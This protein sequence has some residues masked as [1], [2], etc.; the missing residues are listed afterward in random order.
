MA[1]QAK[2][3]SENGLLRKRINEMEAVNRISQTMNSSLNVKETLES[4]MEAVIELG[5]ADRAL[6][7]LLNEA[8]TH[9]IPTVSR[10]DTNDIDLNFEVA[11]ESSLFRY[12]LRDRVPIVVD[13]IEMDSRVNRSHADHLGTTSFIIVPMISK[14]RVIGIIGVDNA[15]TGRSV[16][17]IDVSLLVTLANHAAIA[18]TNSRLHEQT[19][20]FNEQLQVKVKEATDH[21]ERLLEMKSHFLTVA[22]H[23]LRTPTTVIKGLL[24]MISEDPDMPQEEKDRMIEQAYASVNRLE[25]ILSELLTATEFDD[26]A[27]IIKIEQIDPRELVEDLMKELSPLAKRRNIQLSISLPKETIAPIQSDRFKLYEAIANLV[28]N[29]IRYTEEGSVTLTLEDA[30]THVVMRIEDTGIGLEPDEHEVIFDKFHRS[31]A[32]ME[33]KASGTGLGLFITK[34]IVDMLK[35]EIIVHSEGRGKG[36]T[37]IIKIPRD[38]SN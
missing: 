18:L 28:D 38:L 24:S 19:Q 3:L 32:A 11:A 2:Q 35:G 20:R 33:I 30:L 10:G 1:E 13:D 22:S 6:M 4:V 37:F 14:E 9:F 34:N 8:E 23:Q 7:Y 25:R 27:V 12:V 31:H 29:A 36:S 16:R 17:D 5:N 15:E 26:K 21:L